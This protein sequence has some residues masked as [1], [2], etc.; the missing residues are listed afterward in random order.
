M[1]PVTGGE[2][3]LPSLDQFFDDLLDDLMRLSDAEL[4]EEVEGQEGDPAV[5]A[6]RTRAIVQTVVVEHGKERMRTA[7]HALQAARTAP[8]SS[9]RVVR[10]QDRQFVLDRFANDDRGLQAKLTLAARQGG[11]ASD[12]ELNSILGDL[13]ELGAIDEEGNPA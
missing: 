4:I 12:E 11:D 9:E 10:V 2:K 8:A 13:R 5:N 7:R 6:E 1:G 3:P